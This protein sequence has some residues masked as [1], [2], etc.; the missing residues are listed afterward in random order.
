MPEPVETEPELPCAIVTK[1]RSGMEVCLRPIHP[2]DQDKI[3]RGIM[4]LSDRSRYLRFFSSFKV[5]PP[6][7]VEQLS[8]VDGVNHI[9][10]GVVNLDLDDHPPIA[11]AHAIR[12]EKDSKRGEFAIAV[13][14]DYQS[15]GVSRA[16]IAALFSNCV[17]QGI[18]KLDIAVLRENKKAARLIAAL[19][20]EIMRSEG[21]VAYYRLDLAQTLDALRRMEKPEGLRKIWA[22]F[23]D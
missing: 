12:D 17:E 15:K 22:A 9:A 7:V 10:W 19:G 16:L 1:L 8:A 2:S 5:A 20:A 4:E 21:T 23:D 11:A 6:S 14:D 18:D 3:E 13:L